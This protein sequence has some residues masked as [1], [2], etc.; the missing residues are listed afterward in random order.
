MQRWTI[1]LGLGSILALGVVLRLAQYLHNREFWYDEACLAVAILQQPF[2]KL[3][4]PLE[5]G[6]FPIGFLETVKLVTVFAGGSEY[7]S[8]LYLCCPESAWL[9]WR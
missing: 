3:T 5:A 7:A 4:G 1:R 6:T 2:S 8:R 9:S